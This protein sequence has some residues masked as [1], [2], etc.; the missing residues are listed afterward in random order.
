MTIAI[1]ATSLSVRIGAKSLLDR[2]SFDIRQGETVALVGPNGA[3]KSTLLRTL[4]G[5]IPISDGVVT[6][7][8]RA[9]QAWHPR[10]LAL[11]RAVLSQNVAVTFPFTVIEIVRMG[12]GERRGKAIDAMADAALADVDLDGFQHRIVGTLSGGEQQRVHFARVMLQLAC[13]EATYGPGILLLDEP[14]ASLDLRHQLDLAGV[15]KQFGARG[16]TTVAVVHD[17]NL[18]ALMADRVI[19]LGRGRIAADGAPAQAINETM[20]Q[21]TF[22]VSSALGQIPDPSVPFVLPHAARRMPSPA[23]IAMPGAPTA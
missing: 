15:V 3:G 22:G 8:G 21:D 7:K 12:A 5:E 16:T 10:E 20:L 23:R 17:L 9:P 18:A 14:T 13:G 1:S 4:A 6:L 11:R 19:V 2:I